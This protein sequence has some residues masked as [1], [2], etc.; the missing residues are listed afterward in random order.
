MLDSHTRGRPLGGRSFLGR[1]EKEPSVHH[2]ARYGLGPRRFNAHADVERH[3]AVGGDD[4]GVDIEFLDFRTAGGEG[5]EPQERV[6]KG[7]LISWR[8]TPISAQETGHPQTVD[9]RLCVEVGDRKEPE[10]AVANDL[11]ELA[12]RRTGEHGA[13]RFVVNDPHQHFNPA[14]HHRLHDRAGHQVGKP[15]AEV[16]PCGADGR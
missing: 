8:A 16:A 11:R 10:L 14:A 13:E 3:D 1:S 15:E 2:S 12:P 5:R 4:K 9:H 7:A 6:A